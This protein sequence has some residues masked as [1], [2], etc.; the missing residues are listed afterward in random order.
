MTPEFVLT[1]TQGIHLANV[2]PASLKIFFYVIVIT[3]ILIVEYL[4]ILFVS[5]GRLNYPT[6][7]K[8]LVCKVI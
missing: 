5:Y 7:L 1:F 4:F 2:T 6:S 3:F 8:M